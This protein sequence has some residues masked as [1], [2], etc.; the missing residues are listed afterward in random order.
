[1]KNMIKR[2]IVGVA[3]GTILFIIKGGNVF[4][5]DTFYMNMVDSLVIHYNFDIC[6]KTGDDF[7]CTEGIEETTDIKQRVGSIPIYTTKDN[8]Y[9]MLKEFDAE[10]H[11][12]NQLYGKGVSLPYPDAYFTNLNSKDTDDYNNN[13]KLNNVLYYNNNIN[14]FAYKSSNNA[15]D[16]TEIP[17]TQLGSSNGIIQLA[18]GQNPKYLYSNVPY[19]WLNSYKYLIQIKYS[20]QSGYTYNGSANIIKSIP[21]FTST[22]T[23]TTAS[24]FKSQNQNNTYL[25]VVYPNKTLYLKGSNVHTTGTIS[26]WSIS[27]PDNNSLGNYDVSPTPNETR[28]NE[29]LST[30]NEK[31][32]VQASVIGTDTPSDEQYDNISS[33]INTTTTRFNSILGTF[34][35]QD[36]LTALIQR[37]IDNLS[38]LISSD[39]IGGN[40][41]M[42][43][44]CPV[45]RLNFFSRYYQLDHNKWGMELPCMS[46]IYSTIPF[47]GQNSDNITDHLSVIGIYQVVLT[48]YL[49]YLLVLSWLNVIKYASTRSASEIEVYEL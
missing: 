28:I 13:P 30:I 15:T 44:S 31:L 6:I 37:P 25:A 42:T 23:G 26:S 45:I 40:N 16:F 43:I 8:E 34:G 1:M 4:A 47:V 5:Y 38:D 20:F 18:T 39:N 7:L 49:T 3:I 14:Y 21:Y 29:S 36:F 22:N 27:T 33:A 10:I 12:N 35:F 41:N 17:I 9:L 32:V 19:A 46:D 48:G 24:A 11:L 2:I